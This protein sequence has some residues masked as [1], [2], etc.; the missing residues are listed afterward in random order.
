MPT[1]KYK[2]GD[3]NYQSLVGL[4]VQNQVVQTT[5]QSTTA[6][7]SQ[8]A[9]SDLVPAQASPSN[10]LADKDFVNSSITTATAT[11]RGSYNL[12]SDLSLT[13]SA[14][15]GQIE[16]AL[17]TAATGA[18]NNDYSYVQIP[19]SDSTPTEIASVERYKF[20]GT[21]WSFEYALNNS[22][23][24]AAQWAAVNSGI[25]SGLV[26]KLGQLTSNPQNSI[27]ALFG[28]D[29]NGDW[30]N[31][32]PANLASVLSGITKYYDLI[33][34]DNTNIG[35]HIRNT[36]L[37]F[38]F[39]KL[40]VQVAHNDFFSYRVDNQGDMGFCMRWDS[41]DVLFV[42]YSYGAM[43]IYWQSCKGDTWTGWTEL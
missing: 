11:Y 30:Q 31:I 4:N 37:N 1:L 7:M 38:S 28:M 21:R 14:S 3:G 23:F 2:D 10:Q 19:T 43:K 41:N 40:F 16:T 12:V 5:G 32:T 26:A 20:N 18:D 22:G 6:V 29:S 33:I 27:A 39:Y 9:V 35:A 13:I 17:N 34:Q 36:G 24:T 8:K 25:T 42:M 15:H